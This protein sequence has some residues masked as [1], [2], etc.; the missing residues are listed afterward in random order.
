MPETGPLWHV[1]YVEPRLDRQACSDISDDLGFEVYVPAERLWHTVRGRRVIVQR[2]L[3]PRYIFVGVDP[4]TQGWQELL[5]VRGVID[6]LGRSDDD[7]CHPVAVP[8]MWITAMRKAEACGLF[9]HTTNAPHIFQIGEIIRV[10]EG[11]F[12]GYFAEIVSFSGKMR[13]AMP[14]KRAKLA[15]AFMGRVLNVEMD[16]MQLEKVA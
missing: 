9:D 13:S 6:V 2:S 8:S 11:P 16:V 12:A 5:D 10:S 15:M 7:R 1:A 4:W 3:F 14:S